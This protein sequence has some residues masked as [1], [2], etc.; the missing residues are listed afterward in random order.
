MKPLALR[1]CKNHLINYST[2]QIVPL[3]V[4]ETEI[5]FYVKNEEL[6][7]HMHEAYIK[8]GRGG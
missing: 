6:Y 4:G 7:D 1:T 2:V 3:K 5:I 8:T